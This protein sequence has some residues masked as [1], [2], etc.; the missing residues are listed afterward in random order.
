M[1]EQQIEQIREAFPC[2]ANIP[3]TDWQFAETLTAQPSTPHNIREGHVLDHAMFILSGW[4]RVYKLSAA[5]REITLY[6]VHSGQCCVLM[7]ASILGE[8]EYEA[9]V[10]IETETDVLLLPVALF[11]AWMDTYPSVRKF[12][13]KQFVERMTSVTTLL[14]NVAFQ[15]IPYRVAEYLIASSTA[16]SASVR[17]THERLA[18]ELGSAREVITRI[19]NEF[20]NKGAIALSR[21]KITIENRGILIDI[22]EQQ[23]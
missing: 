19:L 9:S 8:T 12:I 23:V 6:R 10:S 4:V 13:Y 18:I 15:S 11:R 3:H 2:F 1:N 16:S 5:G 22:L 21:G 7:M 17:I 20:A 14:E